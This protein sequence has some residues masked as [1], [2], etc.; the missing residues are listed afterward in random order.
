[1]ENN[2]NTFIRFDVIRTLTK[3][4]SLLPI[5]ISYLLFPSSIAKAENKLTNGLFQHCRPTYLTKKFMKANQT[6][7]TKANINSTMVKVLG[8]GAPGTGVIIGKRNNEYIVI[9]A[10]HVL[11]GITSKDELWVSDYS[12]QEHQ[13]DSKLIKYSNKYDLALFSFIAKKT[14]PIQ[15]LDRAISQDSIS[16]FPE[17]IENQK[18]IIAGHA[19]LT[20]SSKK[21]FMRFSNGEVVAYLDKEEEDRGYDLVY[22]NPTVPGMSGG[23][24]IKIAPIRNHRFWRYDSSNPLSA[25]NE[26]IEY[27]PIMIGIHGQ[28]ELI[29]TGGESYSKS[30]FNLGISSTNIINFVLSIYPDFN[31][32]YI[33]SNLQKGEYKIFEAPFGREFFKDYLIDNKVVYRCLNLDDNISNEYRKGL[34]KA[35]I[36]SQV[37]NGVIASFYNAY[38]GPLVE[39]KYP[40]NEGPLLKV[41]CYLGGTK[42]ANTIVLKRGLNRDSDFK[43]YHTNLYCNYDPKFSLPQM[44][45]ETYSFNLRATHEGLNSADFT[46]IELCTDVRASRIYCLKK[47]YLLKKINKVKN[48]ENLYSPRN[49]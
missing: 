47:G 3:I 26:G 11:K 22:T 42:E 28:G 32:Q 41:P 6:N 23:P 24:V 2:F 33:I 40:G 8:P 16:P 35:I 19:L 27:I 21:S 13:A 36:H 10:G 29:S 34:H 20:A 17:N 18:L 43:Q 48:L 1:M 49:K 7:W 30:G 15:F 5:S 45:N 31:D 4:I 44:F 14:L 9:T 39:K 25:F 38:T 37:K 46:N 12:G